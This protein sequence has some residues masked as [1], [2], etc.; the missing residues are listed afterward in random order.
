MTGSPQGKVAEVTNDDLPPWLQSADDARLL[1]LDLAARAESSGRYFDETPGDFG[2]S[3]SPK[4][5]FVDGDCDLRNGAGLLVVTGTLSMSGN[6]SFDGVILVLGEGAMTR[7]GGGNG[8]IMGAIV[9]AKFDREWPADEND[10]EHPFLAP[11]FQTNG[12]GNS[13][14]QYNS[15]NVNN[16]MSSLGNRV[17][18]VHEF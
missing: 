15:T 5:T 1:L 3:A 18:G 10:E 13:T 4:F 17:L 14:V 12:G 7:N 11:T 2:T 16:A 9:V 8:D 6:A